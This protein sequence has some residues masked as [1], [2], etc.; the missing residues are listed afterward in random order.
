MLNSLYP[1][2]A[3]IKYVSSAVSVTNTETDV[4]TITGL[5]TGEYKIEL[6]LRI[7]YNQDGG[8]SFNNSS[9]VSMFLETQYSTWNLTGKINTVNSSFNLTS[10]PIVTISAEGTTQAREL[11]LFALGKTSYGLMSTMKFSLS[12]LVAGK[13]CK[14]LTGSYI[15]LTK[16]N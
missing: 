8:L 13:V 14:L 12:S 16:L 7:E 6:Y 2:K 9:S 10:S 5:D 15:I 4:I 3:F 11:R 1:N